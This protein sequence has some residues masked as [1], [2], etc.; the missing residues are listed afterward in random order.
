M[1]KS[2]SNSIDPNEVLDKYACDS[3]RYYSC[4]SVT[5]GADLGFSEA[6]LVT[7]H[8][9]ELADVLVMILRNPLLHCIHLNDVS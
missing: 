9:S 6:A 5:Y 4:T 3:I 8:N 1:S 2:F 7:M